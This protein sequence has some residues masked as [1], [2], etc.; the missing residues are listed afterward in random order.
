MVR[1]K[2][3]LLGTAVGLAALVAT[4]SRT[5][6]PVIAVADGAPAH[7]A[8]LR[9]T[10]SLTDAGREILA[11]RRDRVACGLDR[12]MGGVHLQTGVA[13]WRWDD[14]QRRMIRR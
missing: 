14:D 4:L 7:G 10:V 6:P 11:G 9:G 12:W 3:G 1:T 8:S 13:M 5:S 2:A